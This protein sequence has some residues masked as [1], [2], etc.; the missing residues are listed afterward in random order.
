M[1]K[2]EKMNS[3]S[4][5]NSLKELKRILKP[6]PEQEITTMILNIGQR[7]IDFDQNIQE[8]S[9]KKDNK[10]IYFG[11]NNNNYCAKFRVFNKED[12]PRLYLKLPRLTRFPLKEPKQVVEMLVQTT[13]DWSDAERLQHIPEGRARVPTK[14][15]SSPYNSSRFEQYIK[16]YMPDMSVRYNNRLE[17][18]VDLAC[19][20]W[21]ERQI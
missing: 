14:K 4:E 3:E 7:I 8:I 15:S 18:L 21:K 2:E 11:T 9:Y 10:I 1:V 5:N 13:D 16:H 12:I 20:I 17:M 19:E 6:C